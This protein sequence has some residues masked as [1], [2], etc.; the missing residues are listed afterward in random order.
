VGSLPFEGVNA[1]QNIGI[2]NNQ[3][4]LFASI[5]NKQI[6][7]KAL[8]IEL[9]K[10]PPIEED[11]P[12]TRARRRQLLERNSALSFTKEEQ[13]LFTDGINPDSEGLLT[14]STFDQLQEIEVRDSFI[15]SF[16]K[17]SEDAGKLVNRDVSNKA[18]G[19]LDTKNKEAIAEFKKGNNL[20]G[21][22][23][24]LE[25]FK[26]L[27]LE[28]TEAAIELFSESL[29]LMGALVV[30]GGITMTALTAQFFDKS[31]KDFESENNRLPTNDEK[32]GIFVLGTVFATLDR[33]GAIGT[34]QAGKIGK[35]IFKGLEGAGLKLGSLNSFLLKPFTA[36]FNTTGAVALEAG[37]ESV[38]NVLE[39][40]AVKQDLSKV[41]LVKVITNGQLGGFGGGVFSAPSVAGAALAVPAG[42][43]AKGVNTLAEKRD[44]FLKDAKDKKEG[45]LAAD[46]KNNT[47]TSVELATRI[48]SSGLG[49]LNGDERKARLNKLSELIT[50]AR[51][52]DP[53]KDLSELTSAFSGL[54]D[55]HLNTLAKEK[56]ETVKDNL[57]TLAEETTE[58]N[59]E[60]KTESFNQIVSSIKD[61]T[62]IPLKQLED[63][64]FGSKEFDDASKEDQDTIKNNIELLTGAEEV[65]ENIL[66]KDSKGF[67]SIT[68][69]AKNLFKAIA[70][71][72]KTAA[73][74]TVKELSN[75]RQLQ[76]DKLKALTLAEKRFKKSKKQ[77][78]F[79][80]NS[81]TGFGDKKTARFIKEFVSP[82]LAAIK[83]AEKGAIALFNDSFDG[84]EVAPAPLD[85]KVTFAGDTTENVS[86]DT[87]DVSTDTSTTETKPVTKK[88][89]KTAKTA[90][91]NS[92]KVTKGKL[93][94][95]K[96]GKG[97]LTKVLNTLKSLGDSKNKL[98]SKIL[99]D[100]RAAQ[101]ET[102]NKIIGENGTNE[103][104]EEE[105]NSILE[106]F[107]ILRKDFL[108]FDTT[109][110][111]EENAKIVESKRATQAAEAKKRAAQREKDK[112]EQ[113]VETKK[114]SETKATEVNTKAGKDSIVNEQPIADELLENTNEKEALIVKAAKALV[115][116]VKKG[117]KKI[118]GLPVG[119]TVNTLFSKKAKAPVG[120][121]STVPDFFTKIRNDTLS[122]S[123]I[124]RILAL[125]EEETAVLEPLQ[126]F[127]SAFSNTL[128]KAI[129][130][131]DSNAVFPEQ[132]NGTRS[133][134]ERNPL[135]FFA[136]R[137]SKGNLSL[138]ENLVSIMSTVGFNW[139]GTRSRETLTNTADDINSI[140]GA[141]IGTPISPR[142]LATFQ[143][144]GIVRTVLAENLGRQVVKQ[145][146][147]KITDTNNSEVMAK[148][149]MAVGLAMIKTME[150]NNL[151]EISSVSA[152][153]MASA[154]GIEDSE[155]NFDPTKSTNFVR[156]KSTA[157]V[158]KTKK[159]KANKQGKPVLIKSISEIEDLLSK[160]PEFLES[161]F[162]IT[163]S[164]V[165][166]GLEPNTEI[167]KTLK[168]NK[169][170]LPSKFKKV[171]QK[172]QAVKWE[173]KQNTHNVVNNID[174]TTLLKMSGWVD[175]DSESFIHTDRRKQIEAVN[176]E[177]ERTID[178]YFLNVKHVENNGGLKSPIYL[179]YEVWKNFRIG[180][181]N[182]TLNPQGSKIIR[183]LIGVRS[184]NTTVGVKDKSRVNFKLAVAAAFGFGIDKNSLEDSLK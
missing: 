9:D 165:L 45:Q 116:A 72:D 15:D 161:F 127:V 90:V 7:Q 74:A 57:A 35:T 41:D 54:V 39:Q 76:Q 22:K 122:S 114:V 143:N 44:A 105:F 156:A 13:A 65:Q 135:L 181:K 61:G 113:G 14:E 67:T 91:T 151:V 124:T 59:K 163:S 100:E 55:S 19:T 1:L 87:S 177:I 16:G 154:N 139:L 73:L 147:I 117:T 103:V 112:A 6:E 164:K 118:I 81:F 99:E 115:E 47:G 32:R 145:L 182:N 133:S 77:E 180:I 85:S 175:L 150:D 36:G 86:E 24:I 25:A 58:E 94:L 119:T 183:H 178:N 140:I 125:A 12:E 33:V 52:E 176:E 75:L 120:I 174:R 69:H 49:D 68:T 160:A 23:L 137:D 79:K 82:D 89:A 88:T 102:L 110:S 64:V 37:T 98:P 18:L 48:V 132:I 184:W 166:A 146:G 167:P 109:K 97:A 141:P 11:T 173:I 21:T 84:S 93:A 148:L 43:A 121:L 95:N 111:G 51:K 142:N 40:F 8:Q 159:G 66:K 71:G 155:T 38:Q 17:L 3:R 34:A 83:L 169:Q 42:V 138:P 50:K 27:A 29:P 101:I 104:S 60:A 136:K 158:I 63:T 130:E 28:D 70:V 2:S 170:K 96:T 20:K 80:V 157:K 131:L 108:A 129:L 53:E 123:V 171:L 4:K 92:S 56:G 149:E 106:N 153:R 128:S 144:V 162:G 179:S 10:L 62:E 172:M 152:E 5:K 168:G 46:L 107:K 134:L 31:V 30:S 126:K 26:D 78:D